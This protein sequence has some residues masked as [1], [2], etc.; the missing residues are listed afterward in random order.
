MGLFR[1]LSPEQ[2]TGRS[3]T[4]GGTSITTWKWARAMVEH[5]A[6]HRGQ[7]YFLLGL[8]HVPT[9]PIFGLTEPEVR[10]R[11]VDR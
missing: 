10:A 9:P 6:H 8:L 3:V 2:W 5:E 11:S 7:M 4:P 1:S